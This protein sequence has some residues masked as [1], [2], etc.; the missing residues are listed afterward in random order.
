M[1]LPVRNDVH[2]SEL[3]TLAVGGPARAFVEAGTVAD[4]RGALAWAREGGLPVLVVGGGSN[5]VVSDDGFPGLVVRVSLRGIDVRGGGA[6]ADVTAAAGE[7]WDPFVAFTVERGLAGLECLSGIPGRVG[8]TPI[9]NVGAYGQE[10]RETIV[11]VEALDTS[12]GSMVR[13]TNEECGF[14]Y[15]DSRFKREDRGRFVVTAVTFR[16]RSGGGPKIAYADLER[17]LAAEAVEQPTLA[18]VRRA[19]LE[20][21]RT[22]SMVIDPADENRRSV[23]SFFMNP[24]VSDATWTTIEPRLRGAVGP[25]ARVPAFPTG[26]GR[27]KLSAAWLI[28]HAGLQRGMRHGGVGISTRH[29]LAIVNTGSGTAHEVVTLARRIRQQVEDAFGVRLEPEPIF[30]GVTM[31][32]GPTAAA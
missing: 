10:V 17:K 2:L 4:L 32:E 1:N 12:T 27:V 25:D 22:K 30:V 7:E 11:G 21:R 14:A 15:R 23:G 13:L 31:G 26:D 28:E 19:V 9:Q 20:V 16:L 24:I 18:D 3:C 5:L 8:A 29:T 6:T